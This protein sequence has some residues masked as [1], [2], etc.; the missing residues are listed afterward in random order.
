MCGRQL[1]TSSTELDLHVLSGQQL[2]CRACPPTVSGFVCLIL[3]QDFYL[4]VHNLT[5]S[6][7]LAHH[8]R[9][10]LAERKASLSPQSRTLLDPQRRQVI[11]VG[12]SVGTHKRNTVLEVE[13]I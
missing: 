12:F 3:V 9:I 4:H 11:P 6:L 7:R 5:S 13:L 10:V 1:L 2:I 8:V